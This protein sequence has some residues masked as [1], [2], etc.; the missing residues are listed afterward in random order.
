MKRTKVKSS[1]IHSI[2]YDKETKTL[3]VAF[4]MHRKP[5]F[6]NVYQYPKC[7]EDLHKRLMDAQS[8]G[9]FFGKSIRPHWTPETFIKVGLEEISPP[10]SETSGVSIPPDDKLET[11]DTK[12]VEPIPA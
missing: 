10:S 2:G 6:V 9:K 7:H 12:P 3:E 4:H 1:Q 11:D 8:H 5:G